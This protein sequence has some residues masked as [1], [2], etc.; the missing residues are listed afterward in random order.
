MAALADD[1]LDFSYERLFELGPACPHDGSTP[2]PGPPARNQRRIH[3]PNSGEM[4]R[5]GYVY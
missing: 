1:A 4:G 2:P 3:C 5:V